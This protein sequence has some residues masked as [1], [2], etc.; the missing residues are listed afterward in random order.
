MVYHFI[1]IKHIVR[2][3][4][5]ILT[6]NQMAPTFDSSKATVRV[7][8]VDVRKNTIVHPKLI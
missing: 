1:H 7:N 5:V 2:A 4:T 6:Y 8:S 3:I